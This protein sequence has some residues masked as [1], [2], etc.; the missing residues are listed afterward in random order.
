MN[1]QLTGYPSIDKPW[2]KYYSEEA[3]NAKLPEMTMYQY[4]YNKNKEHMS[5]V[6]FEYFNKKIRF[7]YFFDS[8][9]T[10]AANLVKMGI[11]KGDIVT[12][13]SMH[14]P[15][16]LITIYA[17]NYIGA[18]ANMVYMTI[19]EKEVVEVINNTNSKA[20]F[21]LDLVIE[22]V[23]VISKSIEIPIIVLS[24]SD[25]MP[26]Y[27]KTVVSLKNRKKYS[28]IRFAKLLQY[29]DYK[30]V[31]ENTDNEATAIIV[32]TSG[33]TGEPK[34]VMLSNNC[35]NAIA[36]QCSLTDKNYK[37][38]ETYLACI[39]P[40]LGFGITMTHLGISEGLNYLPN[41]AITRG[42]AA[43]LTDRTLF[44][45]PPESMGSGKD[46]FLETVGYTV[47]EDALILDN[48][49][50]NNNI[51]ILSGNLK[52]GNASTYVG[53]S[54]IK[55]NEGEVY[56]YAVIDSDGY[57]TAVTNFGSTPS[58]TVSETGTISRLTDNTIEYTA[59]DGRKTS[60][61]VEDN[62][63]MYHNNSK[64]TFSTAKGYITGG[65]EITFYGKGYGLWNVA[66][67][68]GSDD[69]DPVLASKDY[70]ENDVTMEGMTINK[71]NLIVY[72]DGKG[73]TLSDIKAYD[74]VYYNQKTNTMDVYSK[75]VSGAYYDAK[76]SKAYVETVT[77]GGKDYEIG[78]VGATNRLDAST[79]AFE[80]GDKIT[81]ILGKDD[82]IVFVTDSV[83]GVDYFLHG[84][85]LSSELR[86]ATSGENEGNTEFITKMFMANGEVQDIVTNK[87]YK[88]NIGD[89]MR[90]S[91]L[92]GKATL[93]KSS[94]RSFDDYT[95]TIDI[96]NRTIGKKYVLKDAVIIQRLSDEDATVCECELLDF[97]KLTATRI[98]EGNIINVVSAN[99]FGDVAVLYVKNLENTYTYG[100][101]TRIERNDENDVTGYRIFAN[102][103]V[104][105]YSALNVGRINTAVGAGVGFYHENGMIKKITAL[106]QL[107]SSGDIDAVEGGRIMID[108]DIYKMAPEVF[109][110]DITSNTNIRNITIDELARLDN[111]KS[112]AIYSDKS[113]SNGGLVRVI[114][115]KTGE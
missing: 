90:I 73:A 16:T 27:L 54:G 84:V 40:F 108:G 98:D 49:T 42:D 96:N 32:Y 55:I 93:T 69:I 99:A 24:V 81:L 80:I 39:P 58:D 5:S 30:N 65:T 91:Y 60:Y 113:I 1:Q 17:L 8:I 59:Q 25:S 46:T 111:I 106:V 35:V 88:D 28:Y 92:E 70:S 37:R 18:I 83:S 11:S 74:V 79:G 29:T 38:G 103:A 94:M 50:K 41:E 97:D 51:S 95:G 14:T 101:L 9:K 57:L 68:G 7:E 26:L 31:K 86:T 114:T 62:F 77:V 63:V 21:A 44:V 85:V 64:L 61:K 82:K 105:T 110:A 4:A 43:I 23:D 104:S 20:F 67:I 12:I 78:Y 112:V 72:R 45:R 107:D 13:M 15:E 66:V 10:V 109:I 87:L 75:K 48:D 100:V 36:F 33:T 102:G 53:R 34:G 6:C 2:L 115:V 52:L 89:L 47:L 19:S 22:K 56:K 76:P 71:Q 3:I